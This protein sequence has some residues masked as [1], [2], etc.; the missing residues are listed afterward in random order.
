MAVEPMTKAAYDE[1]VRAC[2]SHPHENGP[3]RYCGSCPWTEEGPLGGF[4]DPSVED[5]EAVLAR[6]KDAER[7]AHDTW[8]VAM[9]RAHAAADE[10]NRL[11]AERAS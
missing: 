6:A 2:R 7:L 8:L 1:A 9:A 3:F 11:R 5:A 4:S 10:V